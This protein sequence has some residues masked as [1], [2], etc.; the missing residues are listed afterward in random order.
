MIGLSADPSAIVS[1]GGGSSWST[2]CSELDHQR[3]ENEYDCQQ[4]QSITSDQLGR[5]VSVNDLV[6]GGLSLKRKG[7]EY[8]I[9]RDRGPVDQLGRN[10]SGNDLIRVGLI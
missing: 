9:I 1:T 8:V 10:I 7:N 5:S 6:E 3:K 2:T 4:T